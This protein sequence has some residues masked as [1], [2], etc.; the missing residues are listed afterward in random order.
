MSSVR[1]MLDRAAALVARA[2]AW[3]ILVG[4]WLAAFVYAFPGYLMT[5]SIAQLYQAR[6]DRYDDWHPPLMARVWWLVEHVVSGP[7][8]ML[9]LQLGLLVWGVFAIA[10]RRL[11]PGPAAAV[12]ACVVL[13]PPVLTPMAVVWKDALMAGCLAAGAALATSG[14]R[15]D[16][17]E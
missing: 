13:F 16:L 11:A 15:R 5:D 1:L 4:A 9:A 17:A 10:Q 14:R 2:R 8:G 3:P 6:T 7:A 12:T